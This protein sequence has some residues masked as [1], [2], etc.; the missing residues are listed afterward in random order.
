MEKWPQRPRFRELVLRHREETGM[1]RRALAKALGV[2]ETTLYGYLYNG[3]QAPG[4]DSIRRIAA[5]FDISTSELMDDPGVG[6]PGLSPSQLN[7]ASEQDRLFLQTV[8][9]D[10][11]KLTPE[12]KGVALDLWK[13]AVRALETQPSKRRPSK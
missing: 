1:T 2:A 12:Q 8:F 13:V 7:K 6:L 3:H 10:I 5:F 9:R 11:S 4:R